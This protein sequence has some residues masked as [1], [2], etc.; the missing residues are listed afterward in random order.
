MN[1]LNKLL[2]SSKDFPKTFERSI[3]HIK[4]KFLP[5]IN[6]FLECYIGVTIPRCLKKIYKTLKGLKRE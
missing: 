4:N 3:N 6:N 2:L 1:Y 5:D